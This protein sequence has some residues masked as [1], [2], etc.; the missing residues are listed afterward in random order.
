M[1]RAPLPPHE[2]AWRHPSELAAAN[3]EALSTDEPSGTSRAIAL[4]GGAAGVL[5]IAL[6]VMTLA[7]RR[8][9]TPV[10]VSSTSNPDSPAP[11]QLVASAGLGRDVTGRAVRPIATPIGDDGLAVTT[12]RALF[13]LVELDNR[14]I[15]VE[16]VTGNVARA[17]VVDPGEHG[18]IAWVSVEGGAIDHGLDVAIDLPLADDVVTVLAHPPMLVE[19]AR[20]GQVE[21]ADGTPVI[22]GDGDIV[23]LCIQHDDSGEVDFTPIDELVGDAPTGEQD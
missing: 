20:I 11:A 9:D 3:R 19:Y 4:V 12:S 16:L 2:R 18:G 17:F 5:A 10:A 15:D 23:G 6:L 7:P 1:D 13:G 8:N 22:D 14:L 21:A